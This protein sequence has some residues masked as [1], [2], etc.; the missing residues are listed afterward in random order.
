[1]DREFLRLMMISTFVGRRP[2]RREPIGRLGAIG[3]GASAGV[4][5]QGL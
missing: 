3:Q 1:M 4:R 5:A 2:C